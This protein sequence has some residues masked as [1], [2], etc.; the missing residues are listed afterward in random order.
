M[1]FVINSTQGKNMIFNMKINQL[2]LMGIDSRSSVAAETYQDV[3]LQDYLA[4]DFASSHFDSRNEL[5]DQL[6]INIK[7][8]KRYSLL[9]FNF[10]NSR[11]SYTRVTT[12]K[13]SKNSH[14]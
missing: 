11:T 2:T 6:G 9:G 5:F 1:K 10:T 14:I 8:S 4:Q 7:N 12:T 13:L 3:F